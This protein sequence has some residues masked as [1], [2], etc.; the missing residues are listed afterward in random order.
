[1]S[2]NNTNWIGP[3]QS[4]HAL[5]NLISRSWISFVHD[6]DPNNH[7]VAH[8]PLWPEY[9]KSG[10]N[11]VFAAANT[12]VEPDTWRTKQLEFWMRNFARLKT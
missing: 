6:L 11:I 3:Y 7:G 1:M 5:S 8:A 2:V 4:Y 12:M 9:S 10:K